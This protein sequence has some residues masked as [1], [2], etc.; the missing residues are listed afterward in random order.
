MARAR[1]MAVASG[2]AALL[3]AGCAGYK[4]GPVNGIPAG[5]RAV[6]VNLFRNETFEP[7]LPE[8]I[9]FALRRKL[10]QDGT[11]RLETQGAGDVVVNGV[12]MGVHRMP[13]SFDA[14]D[15]LT[16]RDYD[17]TIEAEVTAVDRVT[18]KEI[19]HKTFQ[20]RTPIR[21]TPNRDAAERQSQPNVADDLAKNI[22]A[23]LTEGT[24]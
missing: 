8:A 3:L 4:V 11:F 16:T 12:I 17:L 5:S 13:L 22:A 6:T 9:A 7:R 19:L 14:K 10:Q 20:G 18:G 24:W 23:A 21:A 2:L 15:I 1:F